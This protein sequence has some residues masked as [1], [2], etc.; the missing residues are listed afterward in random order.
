MNSAVIKKGWLFKESRF[1]K[2]WWWW[3][4]VMTESHLMTY[5]SEDITEMSTE[6]IPFKFCNGV[7]S[8]EDET[9]K[10]NSFRIDY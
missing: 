9:N 10:P 5:K 3:Y 8:A 4:A 2:K 6:I 1:L 7:K